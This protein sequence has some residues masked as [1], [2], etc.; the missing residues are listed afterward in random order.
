MQVHLIGEGPHREALE[1][2][3]SDLGIDDIVKLTGER[4]DVDACLQ[5]ADIFVLPS[6]AEG[7]SNA[8]LQAM[9][10]GLPVIVSDIPGN[11]DVIDHEVNGLRFS[12]GDA[13]SLADCLLQV[14]DDEPLRVKLG[15]GARRSVERTYA[16]TKVVDDY[17]ALYEDLLTTSAE[18]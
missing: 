15:C 18:S 13:D 17:I 3:I 1:A 9:S 4:D 2:R 6:R 14:M 10:L 16:L 7:L 8:L 5:A 11:S 12:V